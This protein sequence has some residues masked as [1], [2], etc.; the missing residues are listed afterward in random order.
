MGGAVATRVPDQM[1]ELLRSHPGAPLRVTVGFASAFGVRW[2]H[3][4]TR[5]RQVRL[6]IGDIRAGFDNFTPEDRQGAI[7]FIKRPDVEVLNWYSRREGYK[8]VHAK[9][10]LIV[11]SHRRTA[12]AL[13][14]YANLTR[15]GLYVNTEAMTAPAPQEPLATAPQPRALARHRRAGARGHS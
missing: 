8:T 2:L 5:G 7:S 6:L 1:E 14:G 13:V 12:A 15:Q 9:A 11:P 3:E 10:W 4:R